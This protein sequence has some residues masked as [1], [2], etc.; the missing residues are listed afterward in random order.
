M[1]VTVNAV[2][3]NAADSGLGRMTGTTMFAD[4]NGFTSQCHNAGEYADVWY[5][6]NNQGQSNLE[7]RF[8]RLSPDAGF[9]IDLYQSCDSAFVYGS[10]TDV[11]FDIEPGTPDT[12]IF[13]FQGLSDI[14]TTYFLRFA[15]RVTY[16]PPGNFAFTLV[17][18]E[19]TTGTNDL[20]KN[21]LNFLPNPIGQQEGILQI[22]L[23]RTGTNVIYHL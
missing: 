15:T 17:D 22:E 11:C 2:S 5:T 3:A 14:P 9:V 7:L 4:Q 18:N 6:F 12:Q 8:N 13:Q 23:D 16:N 10:L 1:L 19:L 20:S 21:D